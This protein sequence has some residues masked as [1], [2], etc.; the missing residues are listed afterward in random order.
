ML[1]KPSRLN[2]VV[3]DRLAARVTTGLSCCL[4]PGNSFALSGGVCRTGYS[5]RGAAAR[6]KRMDPARQLFDHGS[7]VI[8]IHGG[9]HS[10]DRLAGRPTAWMLTD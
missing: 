8:Y 6:K 7:R 3:A 10:R 1:L 2:I 5:G 9:W 4:S